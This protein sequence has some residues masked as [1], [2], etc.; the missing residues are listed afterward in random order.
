MKLRSDKKV[1]V[2]IQY[3]TSSLPT[4][5]NKV[6]WQNKNKSNEVKTFHIGILIKTSLNSCQNAPAFSQSASALA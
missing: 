6:V 2:R 4:T 5:E 3:E 1:S